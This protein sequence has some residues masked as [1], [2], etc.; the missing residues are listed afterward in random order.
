MFVF[1][2]RVTVYLPATRW[3]NWRPAR[4][5]VS[6]LERWSVWWRRCWQP[7]ET[8]T[9]PT[10]PSSYPPTE[11]SPAHR[12]YCSCFWT[13]RGWSQVLH[14]AKRMHSL[15]VLVGFIN[16]ALFFC[17]RYGSVEENE[18]DSGTCRSSEANGAIR[19]WDTFYMFATINSIWAAFIDNI[20]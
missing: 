7:S 1:R 2:R 12:L 4:S 19:K 9:S 10:P 5:E 8:T 18:Q 15:Y 16:V 11:P 17:C 3:A 20:L 14:K 13:G 6:V